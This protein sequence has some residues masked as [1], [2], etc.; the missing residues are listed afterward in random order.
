MKCNPQLAINQRVKRVIN[1]TLVVGVD[2]F[3]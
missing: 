3:M 1:E 2:I